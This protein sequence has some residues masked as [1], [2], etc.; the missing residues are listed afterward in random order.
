MEVSVIIVNYNTTQLT[1]RAIN[2][3]YSI[4]SGLRYE[5]IVVD[6][7]SEKSEREELIHFAEEHDIML[8]LSKT[9]QGFGVAN[10]IGAQYAK[11]EYLLLLNPDTILINNAIDI[12]Y[13]FA[14]SRAI[15]ICGGNLYDEKGKPVH[16]YWQTMPGVYF[17]YCALINNL[18]LRLRY[19]GSHEHNFTG[20][21]M[22]VSYITGADLMIKRE[23][24]AKLGGFD[25]S[26]F[27]YFEETDL[28][29]RARQEGVVA[30]SVPEAKIT[31]LESRSTQ[32]IEKKSKL[33]YESRKRYYNK[34]KSV[35]NARIANTILSI[36]C[37][38]RRALFF[39][40]GNE[41]KLEFWRIIQ[42]NIR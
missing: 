13:N 33:F 29:L 18:N 39:I 41:E 14:K 34:N 42:Q 15:E 11:G 20:K 23:L 2:S 10:N 1:K 26:Y 35:A 19:R 31:H 9:N 24:F 16:S 28:Q 27:M 7:A 36:N 3:I 37:L 8:H 38:L 4:K 17:E 22:K 12:L 25:S 40:I 5:I 30:W 21:P 6:N 32:N